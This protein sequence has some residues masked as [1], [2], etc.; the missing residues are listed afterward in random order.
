MCVHRCVS[1]NDG[2]FP[3][4]AF[5]HV[6]EH[7]RTTRT[8]R[9]VDVGLLKEFIDKTIRGA[10]GWLVYDRLGGIPAFVKPSRRTTTHP[11]KKKSRISNE[12]FVFVV[13]L[14]IAQQTLA[15]SLK[16]AIASSKSIENRRGLGRGFENLTRYFV[17]NSRRMA[18]EKYFYRRR[19]LQV[20]FWVCFWRF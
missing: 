12:S 5:A 4:S 8:T 6:S 11:D 7:T 20:V 10:N 17:S 18:S 16:N 9:T 19:L 1:E 15:N 14:K 2:H 3:S 13:I